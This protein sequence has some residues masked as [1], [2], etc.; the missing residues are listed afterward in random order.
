MAVIGLCCAFGVKAQAQ[1][2]IHMGYSPS[3]ITEKTNLGESH[4]AK[5][6]SFYAGGLYSFNAPLLSLSLGAKFQYDRRIGNANAFVNMNVPDYQLQ[7]GVPVLVNYNLNLYFNDLSVT[8][9]YKIYPYVGVM[10]TYRIDLGKQ[11][12]Y[13]SFDVNLMGGLLLGFSQFNLYAGYQFGLLDLD[14]NETTA[15]YLRG[16]FFGAALSF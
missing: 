4:S 11:S 1:F 2:S 7:I 5:F 15:T 10:P 8:Y 16:W 6:H 12:D 13:K 3:V 14:H 9:H